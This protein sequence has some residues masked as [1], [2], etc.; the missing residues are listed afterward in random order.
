MENYGDEIKGRVSNIRLRAWIITISII[1]ALLLYLVVT[2]ALK[3]KVDWITLTLIAT[4]QIVLHCVYFPEGDIFGKKDETF[5]INRTAYN[6][7]ANKI[8]QDKKLTKLREFCE[9]DYQNR[10]TIYINNTLGKLDITKEEFEVL[11]QLSMKDIKCLKKWEH[12]GRLKFFTRQRRKILYKLIFKPIPV[13][14]TTPEVIMGAIEN[15]EVDSIKDNSNRYV[16]RVYL[17]KIL[18]AVIVGLF[19]AIVGYKIRDGFGFEQVAE[20]ATYLT[21]IIIT[22]VMSFS[23]GELKSKVYKNQ[24]YLAATNFMNEFNEWDESV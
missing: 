5:K 24:F 1:A 13:Q 2:F 20:F 9:K 3:Q 14:K 16:F 4:L 11:K 23:A 17:T 22:A 18:R 15:N 8:N 10:K 19:V 6:D 21:T 12:D 7:K